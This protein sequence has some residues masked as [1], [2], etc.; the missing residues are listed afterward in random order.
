MTESPFRNWFVV[1]HLFCWRIVV[2]RLRAAWH[3]KSSASR[4]RKCDF[5]F[6]GE[7]ALNPVRSLGSAPATTPELGMVSTES[8]V[9]PESA[10]AVAVMFPVFDDRPDLLSPHAAEP[11]AMPSPKQT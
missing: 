5:S 2:G 3:S 11:R 6:V 1:I 7:R 4:A 10:I 9:S 8:V